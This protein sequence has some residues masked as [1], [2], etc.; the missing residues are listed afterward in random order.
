[1]AG[2]TYGGSLAQCNSSNGT[3][4]PSLSSCIFYDVTYG[5]TDVPCA[6]VVS[7]PPGP[8]HTANCF[9][10]GANYEL[11]YDGLT[12]EVGVLSTTLYSSTNS[13]PA[14][15]YGAGTGYDLATGI[16][17]VNVLNFVNGY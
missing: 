4:L 14:I 12:V 3:T 7:S 5:D 10:S 6:Y 9:F 13:S 8:G 16:G 2:S 17:T 15:A 11:T 1:M